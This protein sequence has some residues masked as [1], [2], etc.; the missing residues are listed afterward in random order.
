MRTRPAVLSLFGIVSLYCQASSQWVIEPRHDGQAIDPAQL[1]PIAEAQTDHAIEFDKG[2]SQIHLSDQQTCAFPWGAADDQKARFSQAMPMT[3]KYQDLDLQRRIAAP[4]LLLPGGVQLYYG[5]ET[6]R[7]L[8]PYGDD[9]HQA[10]RSDMNW[11]G[12]DKRQSKTEPTA[13]K[14]RSSSTFHLF[15]VID[16]F[17][18][19]LLQGKSTIL[20]PL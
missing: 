8:G 9:C 13:P 4:F 1:Y 11:L 10:T 17:I 12:L 2:R 5:D 7:P 6:A 14:L 18:T 19:V 20:P 16:Y 3:A 15:K